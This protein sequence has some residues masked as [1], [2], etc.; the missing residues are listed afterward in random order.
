MNNCEEELYKRIR[1]ILLFGEIDEVVAIGKPAVSALIDALKDEYLSVRKGAAEA[2]VEIGKPAVPALIDALK[3]E[4]WF[5]R[6]EAA[7]ALGK[8]A[9]KT[10]DKGDH[11]SAL[12]I[13]KDSTAA[14]MRYYEEKYRRANREER[15][16]MLRERGEM[17]KPLSVLTDKI[18]KMQLPNPLNEKEPMKWNGSKAGA[19][20]KLQMKR[21]ATM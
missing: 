1:T 9:E 21:K 6:R 2:L 7:W 16:S 19:E 8:I 12:K 15:Y 5:V 10:A 18:A 11:I 14:I 4:Y 17:L 13:I 3:D 20:R